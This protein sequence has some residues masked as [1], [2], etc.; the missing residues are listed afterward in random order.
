MVK[1]FNLGE[2]DHHQSLED[3]IKCA[4]VFLK[5]QDFWTELDLQSVME[6]IPE[7]KN[8]NFYSFKRS[9]YAWKHIILDSIMNKQLLVI[10]Y[11]KGRWAGQWVV[12]P[13]GVVLSGIDGN[14]LPARVINQEC[15][16]RFLFDHIDRVK[17]VSNDLSVG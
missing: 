15:R 10:D 8:W 9:G 2:F 13:L 5:L 11:S 17:I 3:A 7:V 4:E 14:Y 16:H 12:E 6:T 1:H